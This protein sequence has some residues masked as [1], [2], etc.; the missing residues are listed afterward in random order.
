ME[1]VVGKYQCG[2]RNGKSTTVQIQSMRQILE[3]T[4]EK[5]ISMFHLLIGFNTAYDTTGRNKLFK[6]LKE[7][8]I[9]LNLISPIKLTL[10]Y[11]RCSVKIEN[12]LSEQFERSIRLRK[13]DDLSCILFNH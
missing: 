1:N 13:G 6:A 7:F 8:M 9:L 5:G 3:K 12:N 10:K 2:F 4:S 11:V